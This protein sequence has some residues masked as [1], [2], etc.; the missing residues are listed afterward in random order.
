MRDA[1][2]QIV[3]VST[4]AR[5]ISERKREQQERETTVGF[6]RLVD[7]SAGTR[8]LVRAAATFFQQQSG[9]EAVGVRL[10]AGDDYPYFE[11]RGFP[12]EFLLVENA[13]SPAT[14]SATLYATAPAVP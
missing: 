8:D 9:C 13:L 2:G 7:E 12:Q 1:L 3:G 14:V 5:D 6:L 10:K 11:A 4:V